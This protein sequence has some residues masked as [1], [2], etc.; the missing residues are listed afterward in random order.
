MKKY[1]Q[2]KMRSC[3]NFNRFVVSTTLPESD[4][5]RVLAYCDIKNINMSSFIRT[6]IGKS[7]A[8]DKEEFAKVV[9]AD[10]DVKEL[11]FLQ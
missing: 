9:Q 1:S 2:K 7:E 5:R 3:V 4:Y 10:D 11:M 8:L 6:L